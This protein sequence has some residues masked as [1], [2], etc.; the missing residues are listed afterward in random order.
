MI[1]LKKTESTF[2]EHWNVI[3]IYITKKKML[4]KEA[5]EFL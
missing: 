3:K 1:K 2:T 4:N 5:M